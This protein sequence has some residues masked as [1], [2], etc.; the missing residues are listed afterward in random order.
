MSLTAVNTIIAAAKQHEKN[1]GHLAKIVSEKLANGLHLAI[2]L[3][4]GKPVTSLVKFITHYIQHVPSFLL[5]ADTIT[6]EANINAHTEPYFIVAQNYF[7]QPPEILNHYIGLHKLM[8]SAYLTHRLIEEINDRFIL[9]QGIPLLPMNMCLS[10]VV[11]HALIAEPLA[12]QLDKT[13]AYTVKHQLLF[14]KLFNNTVLKA[15]LEKQKI[16]QWRDEVLH[17]PCLM[18][19]LP[20]DLRFNHQ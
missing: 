5:A 11:I 13:I 2:K 4:A 12:N 16:H 14:E 3:P 20:I 17:W 18:D 19:D 15:Y 9:H 10:N 7:T 1:S 6:Q 8:K